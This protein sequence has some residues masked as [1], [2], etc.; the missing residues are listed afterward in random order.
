MTFK[1]TAIAA[2][3]LSALFAG[4]A[5]SQAVQQV[6][7]GALVDMSGIYSAHGGPG[8]VTAVNMAVEDFGGKV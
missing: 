5:Q 7:I 4:P 2:L 6:K 8:M 3:T 1:R